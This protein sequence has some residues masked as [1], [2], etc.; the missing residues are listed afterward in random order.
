MVAIFKP[1]TYQSAFEPVAESFV[2]SIKSEPMG[3]SK[4]LQASETEVSK[5]LCLRQG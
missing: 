4:M 3:S 1:T 5:F 2:K